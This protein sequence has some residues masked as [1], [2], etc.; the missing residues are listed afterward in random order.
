MP[1]NTK[2][3]TLL[4]LNDHAFEREDI[5]KSGTDPM[6]DKFGYLTG[7]GLR[8]N[9]Q[10]L[11]NN[12][13]ILGEDNQGIIA[14]QNPDLF[15]QYFF[16][17]GTYAR[18]VKTGEVAHGGKK[19]TEAKHGFIIG[20]NIGLDRVAQKLIQCLEWSLH[21]LGQDSTRVLYQGPHS[22]HD[23]AD[24]MSGMV[25][26]P[27]ENKSRFFKTDGNYELKQREVRL[28]VSTANSR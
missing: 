3:V 7:Y 14:I 9:L 24:K 12:G 26:S 18:R 2:S 8:W 1:E 17:K 5:M 11:I 27:H 4:K 10:K 23:I 21:A 25:Y 20:E 16:H 13:E 6:H 15:V 28:N 19:V 22:I